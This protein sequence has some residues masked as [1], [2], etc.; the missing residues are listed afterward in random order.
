MHV[1][2]QCTVSD[3]HLGIFINLKFIGEEGAVGWLH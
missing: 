3:H 2:V 1:P